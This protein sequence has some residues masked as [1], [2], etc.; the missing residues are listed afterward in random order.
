MTLSFEPVRMM[1]GAILCKLHSLA[2]NEVWTPVDFEKLIDQPGRFGFLA[3]LG[4]APVG[5]VLCQGDENECEIITI[6]THPDYRRQKVGRSLMEK[7][8]RTSKRILLEVAVDNTKALEFYKALAFKEIAR[9]N[10]YY[11]REGGIRVD[12]LVMDNLGLF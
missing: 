10:N 1:H 5:F 6:S 9:R 7:L 8:A 12:A 4:K 11:K 3:L 2:F